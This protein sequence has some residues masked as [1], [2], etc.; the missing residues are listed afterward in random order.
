MFKTFKIGGVDTLDHCVELNTCRRKTNRWTMNIFY[1]MIDTAVQNAVSLAKLTNPDKNN[2]ST[3]RE[4]WIQKLG[5]HC[6]LQK[7]YNYKSG[8]CI[9]G[10]DLITE[11]IKCR[12]RIATNE[13]WHGRSIKTRQIL[14]EFLEKV[15]HHYLS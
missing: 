7:N 5:L 15:C 9:I 13:N 2:S 6:P 8:F 3:L 1:F 4:N 11:N 12:Y 14:T 10:L